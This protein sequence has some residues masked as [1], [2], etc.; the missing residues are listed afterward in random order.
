[1]MM[2]PKKNSVPYNAISFQP[3]VN[4][5]HPT[6]NAISC[7]SPSHHIPNIL[8][9]QTD[10]LRHTATCISTIVPNTKITGMKHV[11]PPTVHAAICHISELL[12]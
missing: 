10:N 4:C 6:T 11:N 3:P 5:K 7:L 2:N 9:T 12:L 8:N 1:M